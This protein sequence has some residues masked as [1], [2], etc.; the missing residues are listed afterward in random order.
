MHTHT[1]CIH[2][3]IPTSYGHHHG[4][5][6]IANPSCPPSHL[7]VRF[8]DPPL[9]CAHQ[10]GGPDRDM[11]LAQIKKHAFFRGVNWKRVEERQLTPPFRPDV[12]GDM[13]VANFDED[14]TSLPA[15]DN[16]PCTSPT[17]ELTAKAKD[18][19]SGYALAARRCQGQGGGVVM[20]AGRKMACGTRHLPLSGS[21]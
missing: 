21:C 19:F 11:S 15:E 9:T 17:P 10:P 4:P 7:V 6:A 5:P 3:Y 20:A 12:D 8:I 13:C 16:S 2:T 1:T 18:H 14:F